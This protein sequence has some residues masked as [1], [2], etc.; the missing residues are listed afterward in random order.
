[1]KI[2]ELK[3]GIT[4]KTPF[5][6]G[7]DIPAKYHVRSGDVLFSWSA[8]L[9]VYIWAHGE[10]LL[11]Q[12]LFN[13]T[14]HDGYTKLF[15]FHSLK[16]RMPEFRIRSL[17][18]TMRHIKRAALKEVK[19]AIPPRVQRDLFESQVGPIAQQVL[20]LTA[21]NKNLHQTRDLLL[22][23]LISGELD[24]SELEVDTEGLDA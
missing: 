19:L 15:L 16:N 10:A 22:P 3:N 4:R 18:T 2:A 12:H 13:V 20:I 11:N 1:V 9:D 7:D 5:Y 8:D 23:R 14:P 24:V 6:D 17:G 21:K